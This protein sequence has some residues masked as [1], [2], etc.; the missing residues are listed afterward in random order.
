MKIHILYIIKLIEIRQN[1][2]NIKKIDNIKRQIGKTKKQRE[3]GLKREKG[4]GGKREKKKERKRQRERESYF[5]R[6]A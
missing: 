1:K 4:A 6:L 3:E 5:R 2:Y